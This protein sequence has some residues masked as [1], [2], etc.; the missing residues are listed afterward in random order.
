MTGATARDGKLR[1]SK[2]NPVQEVQ[3]WQ[4]AGKHP[5][6]DQGVQLFNAVKGIA[7]EK[8]RMYFEHIGWDNIR[9]TR[10][11]SQIADP[12]GMSPLGQGMKGVDITQRATFYRFSQEH[13]RH[14]LL[15]I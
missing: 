6:A 10:E 7:Q 11:T 5:E 14:G 15:P 8:L 12:D 9:S 4:L 1:R 13:R 3:I 2:F